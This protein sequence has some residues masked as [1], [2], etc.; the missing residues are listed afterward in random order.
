MNMPSQP[1]RSLPDLT[2]TELRVLA[3]V[4]EHKSNGIIRSRLGL[5]EKKLA[6]TLARL[7]QASGIH[8][9]GESY[10]PTDCRQRLEAWAREYFQ[11]LTEE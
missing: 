8:P 1:H 2:I 4:A 9:K 10:S 6:H 11:R 7:Y 3:L 5:S